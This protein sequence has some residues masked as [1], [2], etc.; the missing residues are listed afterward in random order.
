MLERSQI[1]TPRNSPGKTP[2]GG[3]RLTGGSL[4]AGREGLPIP[5]DHLTLENNTSVPTLISPS[6]P[7]TPTPSC[8]DGR[9]KFS[10]FSFFIFP[11]G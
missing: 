11:D 10:A 6:S 5:E 7:A 2:R 8:F 9:K 1:K 4:C 3:G